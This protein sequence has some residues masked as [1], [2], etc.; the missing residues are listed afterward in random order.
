[1]KT[2]RKDGVK[3]YAVTEEKSLQK[4]RAAPAVP[5]V[6]PQ[7]QVMA[8]NQLLY[9]STGVKNPKVSALIIDQVRR[10]SFTDQRDGMEV[11][12]ETMR[13]MRPKN[14][15]E[16][17]LAAQMNAVHNTALAYLEKAS[18][19]GLPFAGCDANLARATELMRLYREMSE[20]ML[21]LKGQTG[22]QKMTVKHVHVHEGGQAI[23]GT[24]NAERSIQG[25]GGRREKKTKTP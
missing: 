10:C 17:Q 23:V 16:A 11:A 24:V 2:K 5:K 20:M 19:P 6:V 15:I 21:K 8:P 14:L 18:S 4:I 22:Q 3:K 9:E 13:E 1:M 12:L 25:G 7:A